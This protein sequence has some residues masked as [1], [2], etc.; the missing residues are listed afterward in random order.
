MKSI[1]IYNEILQDDD[2]FVLYES[3]AIARYLEE[4]YPGGPGLIPFDPRERALFDQAAAV[5]AS[6]FDHY[7]SPLVFE[8]IVKKYVG[9]FDPPTS[10][11]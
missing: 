8:A 10:A 3:R 6:S 1:H 2:G 9:F 11:S 5:E 7:A 4:N